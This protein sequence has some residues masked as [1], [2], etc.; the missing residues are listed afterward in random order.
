MHLGLSYTG[1]RLVEAGVWVLKKWRQSEALRQLSLSDV[2]TKT[3][4]AYED[5]KGTFLYRLSVAP[6]LEL[7]QHVARPWAR[8]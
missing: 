6:G 3:A 8:W 1:N 7:F 4:T 2:A 5:L